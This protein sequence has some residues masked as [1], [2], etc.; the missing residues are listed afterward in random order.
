MS[1]P[2]GRAPPAVQCLR[3]S[4]QPHVAATLR[5]RY[6][7]VTKGPPGQ[8]GVPRYLSEPHSQRMSANAFTANCEWK[9]AYAA[10]VCKCQQANGIVKKGPSLVRIGDSVCECEAANLDSLAYFS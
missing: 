1:R 4:G 9:K 10:N 2:G 7:R 3:V 5:P 6:G 8:A